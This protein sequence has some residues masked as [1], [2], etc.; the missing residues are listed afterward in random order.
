MELLGVSLVL[1]ILLM[2]SLPFSLLSPHNQICLGYRQA[3]SILNSQKKHW[4]SELVFQRGGAW[5]CQGWRA[6]VSLALTWSLLPVH[7]GPGP[8]LGTPSSPRD[9]HPGPQSSTLGAHTQGKGVA[10]EGPSAVWSC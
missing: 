4:N 8:S 2:V 6:E 7:L 5:W 3:S 10:W 9:A 1:G